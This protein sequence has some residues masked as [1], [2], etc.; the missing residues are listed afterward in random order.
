MKLVA[1]FI[2]LDYIRAASLPFG[3]PTV[4]AVVEA[5]LKS[6]RVKFPKA[7]FTP[8]NPV[9]YLDRFPG[10]ESD[11]NFRKIN[12]ALT[13]QGC[14]V[15]ECPVLSRGA[16]DAVPTID[17]HM[18]A[19]VVGRVI[20]IAQNPQHADVIPLLAIG[21]NKWAALIR[22]LEYFEGVEPWILASGNS[23]GGDL[24]G[25]AKDRVILLDEILAPQTAPASATGHPKIGMRK[26][27][28]SKA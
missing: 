1:P 10:V 25:A 18:S 27:F 17:V 23:L 11:E 14:E 15:V 9:V 6:L 4:S 7:T 8:R 28:G 16:N 19:E 13:A 3:K 5:A 26:S 12:T 2:K 21:E 24:R 20:E 22:T